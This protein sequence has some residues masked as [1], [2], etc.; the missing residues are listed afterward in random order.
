[1]KDYRNG[2]GIDFCGHRWLDIDIFLLTAQKVNKFLIKIQKG[3]QFF[4]WKFRQN[5]NYNFSFWGKRRDTY[6]YIYIYIY[7]YP[8]FRLNI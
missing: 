4:T 5:P 3:H 7:I 1:M 2:F 8:T 6:I